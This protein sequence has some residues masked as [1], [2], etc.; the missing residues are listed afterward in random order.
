M[1]LAA[2][3]ALNGRCA[4]SMRQKNAATT[5]ADWIDPRKQNR[6]T[7]AQL[8]KCSPGGRGGRDIVPGSVRSVPRARAGMT[9]EPR[10]IART[11]RAL[12]GTSGNP[13]NTAT[14]IGA[15]SARLWLNR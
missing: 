4:L 12:R 13:T 11:C 2:V 7:T 3:N 15:S 5:P 1:G 6:R 8:N 14:R 10:S 9:S